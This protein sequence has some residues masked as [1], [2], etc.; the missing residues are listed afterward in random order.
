MLALIDRSK[1]TLYPILYPIYLHWYNTAP[2]WTIDQSQ[3]YI[4]YTYID[5]ILLLYERSIKANIMFLY[6]Y[7]DIILLL[8]EW[9]IKANIMIC[10]F[11]NDRSKP[12]LCPI[13]L[14]WCNTAPLWTIDLSQHYILY[15]YID[16]ILLLYE[17][18]ITA[19][20]MSYIPTLIL[21]LL[22]EWSILA[23]II[24][25]IPTLM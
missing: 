19:N 24:S 6:T 18:S 25:Y 20:I 12:T 9:L 17:W 14:H 15:T 10:S 7:I 1:P 8:Y 22:Y 5:V 4:L 3:H 21:L 23:N 16:V 13:Y 2:S 11:M